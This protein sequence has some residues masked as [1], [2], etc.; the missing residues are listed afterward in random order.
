MASVCSIQDMG[1]KTLIGT[2]TSYLAH[3][4]TI[5]GTTAFIDTVLF[6]SDVT[7]ATKLNVTGI[8]MNSPL[9]TLPSTLNIKDRGGSDSILRLESTRVGYYSVFG[10]GTG[11]DVRIRSPLSRLRFISRT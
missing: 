9:E 11:G 4:N 8:L 1:G 7:L 2:N 10:S 6:N 3:T 5:A